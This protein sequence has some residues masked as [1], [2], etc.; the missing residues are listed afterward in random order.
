V[1][2]AS[3]PEEAKAAA[4]ELVRVHRCL[5]AHRIG[6]VLC[7]LQGSVPVRMQELPISRQVM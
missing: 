7:K 2:E 4:H 5:S 1:T 6:C 3:S